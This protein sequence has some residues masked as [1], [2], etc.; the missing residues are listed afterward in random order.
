MSSRRISILLGVILSIPL[1]WVLFKN[2]TQTSPGF[3]ANDFIAHYEFARDV[4]LDKIFSA[5]I[6]HIFVHLLLFEASKILSID[7]V[8]MFYFFT[9]AA[10]V[11][12]MYFNVRV[13]EL[14]APN[15]EALGVGFIA[16]LS[17]YLGAIP[18]RENPHPYIGIW[19][20]LI[21]H[22]PTVLWLRPMA[23]AL[24][25]LVVKSEYFSKF[26]FS[27]KMIFSALLAISTV[28]KPS[29]TIVLVPAIFVFFFLKIFSRAVVLC[30]LAAIA[31][32]AIQFVIAFGK[33]S[34][35][36]V[37]LYWG[38]AW[39][40]YSKHIVMAILQNLAG[41]IFI[42]FILWRKNI[43]DFGGY[44]LW[45]MTSI[46]LLQGL[47]LAESGHRFE[48]A[49]FLWG[50][51]ITVGILFLFMISK[52][53]SEYKRWGRSRY[54]ANGLLVMHLAFGI[55]YLFVPPEKWFWIR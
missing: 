5:G 19:S 20:P 53:F 46:A 17:L 35:S 15:L 36:S 7:L 10:V 12:T 9:A 49:N 34:S 55:I 16:G 40:V 23:V 29:F 25:Y 43:F 28:V 6:P 45:T 22:N 30:T 3:N 41:V 2:M 47:M 37:M 42:S 44:F 4:S 26:S 27:Q 21:Y 32:L 11:A 13:I 39:Q 52:Y 8:W 54:W 38:G 50:Y 51:T 31:V 33:N 18:L 48:G 24:I 14:V 1:L